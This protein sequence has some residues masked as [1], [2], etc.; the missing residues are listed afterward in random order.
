[1][2]QEVDE[3]NIISSCMIKQPDSVKFLRQ[4]RDRL[5]N[6]LNITKHMS[7]ESNSTLLELMEIILLG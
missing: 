6:E 3:D 5:T 7:S 4:E 1:M 2:V